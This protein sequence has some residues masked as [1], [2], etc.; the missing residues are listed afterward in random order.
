MSSNTI[1]PSLFSTS[2]TWL[3]HQTSPSKAD[4]KN[5][6]SPVKWV[7]KQT[8]ATNISI[9]L[10][11][12]WLGTYLA[13]YF[14]K[15]SDNKFLEL[16][17]RGTRWLS[18]I[19]GILTPLANISTKKA[20]IFES[21][22][23]FF[24]VNAQN[25]KEKLVKAIVEDLET[26][27]YDLHKPSIFPFYSK[28]EAYREKIYSTILE[29]AKDPKDPLWLNASQEKIP[30]N[31]KERI[32][33][34]KKSL[35]SRY[36]NEHF[37]FY[38]KDDKLHY[39][40]KVDN[41]LENIFISCKGLSYAEAIKYDVG[42][43][44]IPIESVFCDQQGTNIWQSEDKFYKENK[45]KTFEEL[46]RDDK[47]DQL[48]LN[49]LPQ[50]LPGSKNSCKVHELLIKAYKEEKRLVELNDPKGSK[51]ALA[52]LETILS[53]GITIDR[54]L[55]DEEYVFK[56][57]ESWASQVIENKVDLKKVFNDLDDTQKNTLNV[58]RDLLQQTPDSDL[59]RKETSKIIDIINLE[60]EKISATKV[61][62]YTSSLSKA[63]FLIA[64]LN[65]LLSKKVMYGGV[66]P[67]SCVIDEASV[68]KLENNLRG[69]VSNKNI[70]PEIK[71]DLNFFLNP[72][73]TS[74]QGQAMCLLQEFLPAR[75][76]D[77]DEFNDCSKVL[78]VA[79]ECLYNNNNRL[80][81]RVVLVSGN[82]SVSS[83]FGRYA[84]R[85]LC[86]P[87]IEL[88]DFN[89][90]VRDNSVYIRYRS[91]EVPINEFFQELI[92][93]GP[94]ILSLKYFDPIIKKDEAREIGVIRSSLFEQLK[95]VNKPDKP[96]VIITGI[97]GCTNYEELKSASFD[98]SGYSSVVDTALK[99]YL[100]P[101]FISPQIS[102]I[103]FHGLQKKDIEGSKENELKKRE[104][105]IKS[106]I[107]ALTMFKEKTLNS[108]LDYMG[109]VLASQNFSLLQIENAIVNLAP[110]DLTQENILAAFKEIRNESK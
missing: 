26:P 110:K 94:I 44:E 87:I 100:D 97:E 81:S 1:T 56:Q 99:K 20:S 11:V 93:R 64:Y 103:C 7:A 83:D 42:S 23:L 98:D 31:L 37:I 9:G 57:F 17:I 82:S 66:R 21:P 19:L 59:L 45:Y 51:K 68:E 25:L 36:R 102:P 10:G 95:E 28:E 75:L 80:S 24:D 40:K 46:S 3:R 22:P 77:N 73:K 92:N 18:G 32:Q 79:H 72:D 39:S 33:E 55:W 86:V 91:N 61:P 74:V 85:K 108:T 12:I 106:F 27:F 6:S 49:K 76:P 16:L 14:A 90:M 60:F 107:N 48:H 109:I 84:S 30:Q 41:V 70:C 88:E 62:V 5:A 50:F 8:R 101:E 4:D 53:R 104:D 69:I 58:C 15:E 43:T 89:L 54:A 71:K 38:S 96:I 34:F 52:S 2:I 63:Q 105:S 67:I 29:L 13:G 35:L 47:D 65:K 78:Q